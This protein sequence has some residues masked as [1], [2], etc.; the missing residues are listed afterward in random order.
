MILRTIFSLYTLLLMRVNAQRIINLPDAPAPTLEQYGAFES[1]NAMDFFKPEIKALIGIGN[2]SA[3]ET[4][5]SR[6]KSIVAEFM[7]IPNEQVWRRE[8]E[9]SPEHPYFFF[10]ARKAGGSTL[11]GTLYVAAKELNLPAYIICEIGN[12]GQR[13][14]CDSYDIPNDQL[15]SIYAG[16]LQWGVQKRIERARNKHMQ[17]SEDRLIGGK[18]DDDLSCVTNLREPVSR[19]LS[20]V[21][22]RYLRHHGRFTDAICISDLTIEELYYLLAVEVDDFSNSCLNEPFRVFSGL[23]DEDLV[24]NLGIKTDPIAKSA[25]AVLSQFSAD[26][27]RTT[28]MRHAKCAPYVLELPDLSGDLL[29]YKFPQLYEAGAFRMDKAS[30]VEKTKCGGNRAKPS[31]EQ[32]AMLENFAAY[33]RVLYDAVVEKVKRGYKQIL[34]DP[35][36]Q[37]AVA[38]DKGLHMASKDLQNIGK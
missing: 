19:L 38:Y 36:I 6:L 8:H 17:S 29:A 30:N 35:E 13:V 10:H 7:A 31:A 16:H 20:C 37:A 25:E 15:F 32:L 1:R 5:Q 34:S 24:N 14:P 4:A 11:R 12:D 28:L 9:I 2:G 3:L 23:L 27:L 26:I 22:Y 33:E 21:N 18:L